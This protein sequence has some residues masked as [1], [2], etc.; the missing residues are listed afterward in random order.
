MSKEQYLKYKQDLLIKD[1]K[2]SFDGNEFL[3][4]TDEETFANTVLKKYRQEEVES[5]KKTTSVPVSTIHFS[6]IKKHTDARNS[7]LLEALKTLPKGILHHCHLDALVDATFLI[8]KVINEDTLYL[9]Y[10]EGHDVADFHF[11]KNGPPKNE[12]GWL[13]VKEARRQFKGGVEMFDKWLYECFT[14]VPSKK[15]DIV[16]TEFEIWKRFARTFIS[17]R[18]IFSYVPFTK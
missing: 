11:Y 2:E 16:F 6:E 8:E 3:K 18:G 7:K 17:I 12:S 1:R 5:F 14:I 9:K 10:R 4:K 15:E 13:K